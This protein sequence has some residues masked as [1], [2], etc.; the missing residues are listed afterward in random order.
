MRKLILFTLTAL[1]PLAGMAALR[2]NPA[3]APILGI[4][5]QFITTGETKTLE[6][7]CPINN[8]LVEAENRKSALNQLVSQCLEQ[9]SR[10]AELKPEVLAV[11]QA[12]VIAPDLAF[13]EERK[14]LHMVN[15]TIFLET[16]V[17]MVRSPR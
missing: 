11:L 3:Q 5:A 2:S 7:G 13:H 10:A 8:E 1:M 17:S 4:P 16:V 12:S 6:W 14:G 15:G 9:A